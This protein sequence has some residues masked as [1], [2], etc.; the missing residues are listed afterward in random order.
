MKTE[1]FSQSGNDDL[2]KPSN[3]LILYKNSSVDKDI[4]HGLRTD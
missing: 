2:G 1:I 4:I 3:K